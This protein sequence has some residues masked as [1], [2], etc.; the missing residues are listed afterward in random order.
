M[1]RELCFLIEDI[2]F[3]ANIKSS[4]VLKLEPSCPQEKQC[5]LYDW[6]GIPSTHIFGNIIMKLMIL[7]NF[8]QERKKRKKRYSKVYQIAPTSPQISE[9]G[10]SVAACKTC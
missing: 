6:C 8:V 9:K 10:A 5:E 3:I 1:K 4:L 7:Y 2:I